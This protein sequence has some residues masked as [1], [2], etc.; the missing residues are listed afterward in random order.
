MKFS[1]TVCNVPGTG[2]QRPKTRLTLLLP[3]ALIASCMLGSSL[4]AVAQTPADHKN[5]PSSQ[6]PD[7]ESSKP[8]KPPLEFAP[9]NVSLKS[10]PR[11]LFMDQKNFFSGPFHMNETQWQW[12]AVSVLFGAALIGSDQKIEQH[13]PTTPTTVSRAS[14]ASNA[15]LGLLVGAGGGLFVLGHLQH[16]DQKRET[17][18]LSGEAAIDA[19]IDTEIFKYAAGRERPFING[20]HGRFF[21]G[22]SSFPSE[23]ASASFAIASVIAHEYPGPLTKILVYGAATGVSLARYAGQKHFM[24]DVVIGGALGWY[25]GWQVFRSQS[26]YS[27]AD[28]AKYGTFT[29][30]E[31]TDEPNS[32]HDSRKMGSPYVPLDSW[33]YTG[34]EKL[35]ALG[36]VKLSF[37]NSKPWTRIDFANLVNEA[38]ASIKLD[39]SAPGE[40]TDLEF[41]LQQEFAYE[42]GVLDGKSN[43]SATLESA[44][45]RITEISGPPLNDS[46]HFGQTIINNFGRP[47]QEGFNSYDGFSGYGTAG[48]FT[49]Y[50]RGEYQ[51]SPFAPGYSLAARDA[52]ATADQNPLQPSIPSPTINQFTL[53][54]TYASVKTAGWNLSFGKQSLWWGPAVG[55]ALIFSDNA[56][57]IYMFRANKSFEEVP[58]LGPVKLDFFFGKLAGNQFPPRPF[59]HGEKISFKPTKNWEVGFERTSELGGV[60]RAL[61]PGAVWESYFGLKSSFEYPSNI[62]PGK[63]TL[64]FDFTYRLPHLRNWATLYGDGLLPV[65]NPFNRDNSHNPIYDFARTAVRTGIYMPRLPNLPKLDFRVEAV[66]TDPPT[67]RSTRGDYIYWDGFYKDL[68]T[69]KNNLIGDWIGREGMGFQAW[70]NYWFN[71]KSSLQFSYRRAKVAKDFI[72]AGETVND[73]AVKLNWWFHRDLNLSAAVQYE[74]WL[75]PILAPTAQTNWTSTIEITFCPKS[76]AQ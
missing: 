2:G 44:Y 62:D 21:V 57:P 66:Y 13:V 7:D 23:H 1:P 43:N 10:L 65:S 48:P 63:R 37:M 4:I 22:G 24:S 68:Y 19:V 20:G 45:T 9:D 69:S 35:A 28:I 36:Y 16:D 30:G 46:Y 12:A 6:K 38:D 49:I 64:G 74:K 71:P 53:L 27:D 58:L 50:V 15:G 8:A 25:Q 75:A 52:I 47:Y 41:E 33:V 11:N 60:G 70:S 32:L 76:R 29:K 39:E 14:T 73:G 54:D 3:A 17:G 67:P 59:I 40:V 5:A 61:T 18:L 31:E 42:L 51:H 26:H 34:V 55:G 72:P 56:E